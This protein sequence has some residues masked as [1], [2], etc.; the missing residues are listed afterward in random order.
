[1]PTKRAILAEPTIPDP[2]DTL[3]VA[4]LVQYHGCA[5]DL[6]R[7]LINSSDY[8]TH[9][10]DLLFLNRP[11]DRFDDEVATLV[12]GGVSPGV[13]WIESDEHEF[14]IPERLRC[15]A[16]QKTARNICEGTNKACAAL[17]EQNSALEGI[18]RG[19]DYND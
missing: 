14:F 19:I 3:S 9:V 5:A 6:C 8:R 7:G 17:D 16:I 2:P 13:T 18:L 11:S 10:F 15:G 12:V 1:M 4:Q